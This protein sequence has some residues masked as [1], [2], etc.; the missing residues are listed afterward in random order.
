M[1]ICTCVYNNANIPYYN[2]YYYYYNILM[3]TLTSFLYQFAISNVY[4]YMYF[5]KFTNMIIY[6]VHSYIHV[7]FTC[8]I[9]YLYK[10]W[11]L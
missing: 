11:T 9:S 3:K 7:I 4:M 6:I 2:D 10:G 1:L 8:M 5:G